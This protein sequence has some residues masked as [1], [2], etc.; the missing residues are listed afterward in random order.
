MQSTNSLHTFPSILPS[1]RHVNNL[2][3]ESY[4]IF[5]GIHINNIASLNSLV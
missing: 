3:F 2:I 5:I 1:Q 4:K